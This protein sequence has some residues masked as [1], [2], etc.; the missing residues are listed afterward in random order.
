MAPVAANKDLRRSPTEIPSGRRN[1]EVSHP[2]QR[3]RGKTKVQNIFLVFGLCDGQSFVRY[4]GGTGRARRGIPGKARENSL[5][6]QS[7]C[8]GRREASLRAVWRRVVGNKNLSVLNFMYIEYPIVTT[9]IRDRLTSG[10][11][12]ELARCRSTPWRTWETYFPPVLV[13]S[14]DQ[15]GVKNSKKKSTSS[16]R[17]FASGST[18]ISKQHPCAMHKHVCCGPLFSGHGWPRAA[19]ART[20]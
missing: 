15:H 6:G 18:G 16:R 17:L 11:R 2:W 3:E 1:T 14:V 9:E 4:H 10:L 19:A 7:T 13:P 8:P 12:S 5:E 20:C